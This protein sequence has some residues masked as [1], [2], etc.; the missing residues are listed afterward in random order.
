[1]A[2]LTEG[3]A[4]SNQA[5]YRGVLTHGWVL[6]QAGQ[7]MHK[8]LGN[9]I[10]PL[11]LVERYGADLLRLW[12][13]SSEYRTDVRISDGLMKQLSETY[14]KLRNTIRFI[15]GNLASAP[16]PRASSGKFLRR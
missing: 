4:M 13:A 1:M 14:R 9:T 11:E 5:P 3:V 12:V 15:L 2:L 16:K 7:E 10:D 8:S 6:D